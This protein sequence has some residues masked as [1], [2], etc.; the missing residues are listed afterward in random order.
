M[1]R[2]HKFF[3]VVVIYKEIV[4]LDDGF[5][6]E[7]FFSLIVGCY[8]FCKKVALPQRIHCL[9]VLSHFPLKYLQLY[10]V[11]IEKVTIFTIIAL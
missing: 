2:D 7:E 9:N 4:L 1:K 3:S 8:L 10:L 5:T 11:I 6:L